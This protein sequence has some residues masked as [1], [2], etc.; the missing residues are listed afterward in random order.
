MP[1]K[2]MFRDR[3]YEIVRQ[4]PRGRVATYGAVATLV[5]SP[6]AARAVGQALKA[7]LWGPDDVPW[8][9]VINAAGRISYRGDDARARLQRALL[10]A[11]GVD[12]DDS[13]RVDL[14][15]F[16]WWG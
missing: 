2:S 3:V 15:R 16:G 7:G 4:I 1:R 14:T 5:Y 11:E 6:R 12:F 8:Q 13:D 10:E 9:R